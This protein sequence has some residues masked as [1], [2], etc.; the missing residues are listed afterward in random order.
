MGHT[1]Y[2]VTLL[3]NELTKILKKTARN[4]FFHLHCPL[5][6]D[7]GQEGLKGEEGVDTI[8]SR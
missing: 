7:S 6:T 1:C 2:P 4:L 8:H 5:V 3:M